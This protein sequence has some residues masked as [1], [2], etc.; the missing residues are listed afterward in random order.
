MKKF[1]LFAVL[2]AVISFAFIA[3]ERPE[4]SEMDLSDL[5]DTATISGALVYD[6]GVDTTGSV[7]QYVIN[8]FKPV[9][10]RTVFVEVPYSSYNFNGGQEGSKI[11]ET[12]TDAQGNFSI[13]IPTT[14]NGL[15]N[16]TIRMQEFTAYRSEYKKMEGSSPVFETDMY[17]YTCPGDLFGLRQ[18]GEMQFEL[19]DIYQDSEILIKA[20]KICERIL[21]DETFETDEKYAKMRKNIGISAGNMFDFPS[22]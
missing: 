7:D 2:L 12:T 14:S 16:V 10:N 4:Q 15:R 22:I 1:N 8:Q 21:K 18:S 5:T 3:C 9:A 19:A 11:F 13:E 20:D 6:A 17:R